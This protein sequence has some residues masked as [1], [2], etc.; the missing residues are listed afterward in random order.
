MEPED[1]PLPHDFS[2]VLGM[3]LPLRVL[4]RDRPLGRRRNHPLISNHENYTIHL[5][6]I[7]Q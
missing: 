4:A 7:L 3:A 6:W 2:V 5:H 1:A